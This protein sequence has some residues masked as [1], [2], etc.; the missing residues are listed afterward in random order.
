VPV[1]RVEE[2]LEDCL[3]SIL[4]QTYEDF[5]LILIDDGSPD[6]CPAICDRYANRDERVVV[7]HKSNEGLQAAWRSGLEIAQGTYVGFVDSDD[8]IDERM[9]ASMMKAALDNDA[10]LVQCGI[11]GFGNEKS[12]EFG[13][14]SQ[15]EI[16]DH[17][18]GDYAAQMLTYWERQEPLALPARWNKLFKRELLT[19]N[20]RYCDGRVSMGEDLNITLAAALDARRIC[21]LNAC[22]YNYR[23]NE[24]GISRSYRENDWAK[25]LLL[26][27]ALNQIVVSKDPSLLSCLDRFVNY[28]ALASILNEGKSPLPFGERVEA[29]RNIGRTNPARKTV[30]R[31]PGT[32]L[33][34]LENVV[35][36][37]FRYRLYTAT[38]SL[39]WLRSKSPK[40]LRRRPLAHGTE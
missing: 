9:Y 2:F 19:E 25:A 8:F 31:F 22:Y 35:R 26:F 10:D 1:F 28:M 11:R 29:L 15:L 20:V 4:A 7:I 24:D 12:W 18:S 36:L 21:C 38:A 6:S 23:I 34:P 40:R 27:Q 13:A 16:L 33:S 17:R 30:A 37:F 14:A 32:G 39:L 5:E 3:D